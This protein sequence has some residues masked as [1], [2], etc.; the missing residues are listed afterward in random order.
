[1]KEEKYKPIEYEVDRS[2]KNKYNTKIR[3]LKVYKIIFVLLFLISFIINIITIWY[4]QDSDKDKE[5]IINEKKKLIRSHKEELK[6]KSLIIDS[7]NTKL[8][9]R[10]LE[11][12]EMQADI[13]NMNSIIDSLKL[14]RNEFP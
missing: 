5:Q 10:K 8:D 4:S 3:K 1:M 11:V 14:E 2:I 12:M 13:D 6:E 9:N 7:L